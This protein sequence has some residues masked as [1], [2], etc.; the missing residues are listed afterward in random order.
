MHTQTF[1]VLPEH[2]LAYAQPGKPDSRFVAATVTTADAATARTRS[3]ERIITEQMQR[4]AQWVGV[5]AKINARNCAAQPIRLMRKARHGK[6]KGPGWKRVTDRKA[7]AYVRSLA[8][9]VSEYAN[10]A[11]DI[12]EVTDHPILDV[13]RRPSALPIWGVGYNFTVQRFLDKEMTGNAFTNVVRKGGIG[14]QMHRLAPHK[15]AVMPSKTEWIEGYR[16]GSEDLGKIVYKPEDV[17]HG[18]HMPSPYSPYLGVSW[19][20]DIIM[21]ADR[22][23]ASTA[24]DLSLKKNNNRPDWLLRLPPNTNADQIKQAREEVKRLFGGPERRGGVLMAT[25]EGIEVPA[26]SPADLEDVA[27]RADAK[28]IIQAAAGVPEA[29]FAMNDSNRASAIMALQQYGR[30]TILPR[31]TQDH[32]EMT[33]GL[34]PFF[35]LDPGDYWLCYDN[36][37]PDDQAVESER[38]VKLLNAGVLTL[39]EARAEDGYEPY[40]DGVGEKPRFN[41][42]PLDVMGTL[43]MGGV[44]PDGTTM[45]PGEEGEQE[46]PKPAAA[47]VAPGQDVQATALN[48]AQVTALN[49]LLQAVADGQLPGESASA[50]IAASY[51]TL[52]PEQI[53][54]M[55]DP[56][57]GF[58]PTKP[59]V[60]DGGNQGAFG[61]GESGGGDG[62]AGG[63]A[64]ESSK[65]DKGD[66]SGGAGKSTDLRP[67]RHNRGGHDGGGGSGSQVKHPAY[68]TDWRT[69]DDDDKLIPTQ[70]EAV[71]KLDTL[72]REWYAKVAG[73]LKAGES[74]DA[75]VM[76]RQSEL[77]ALLRPAL[78]QLMRTAAAAELAQMGAGPEAFEVTP[79]AALRY[80]DGYTPKLAAAITQETTEL[81]KEAQATGVA[82]GESIPQIQER[83]AAA[84][85][86]ETTYRAERIARTETQ[87]IFGRG[88]L[89]AWRATGIERK[90]WLLAPNSCALCQECAAKGAIPINEPFFVDE[91]G[92]SDG[93]SRPRHP[94][95]VCDGVAVQDTTPLPEGES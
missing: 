79:Q 35:G 57:K 46:Q 82:M 58:E 62:S 32:D 59:E 66:D 18:I 89:E 14:A 73:S 31:L 9:K 5:C 94:N 21:D 29:I 76:A 11:D 80:L 81:L 67:A 41:G 26:W 92:W 93:Q 49:A 36:P 19:I 72:L 23:S 22:Y 37:V 83:V 70:Q 88:D 34:L 51:P 86:E 44:G 25:A 13:L 71:A 48:G 43:K 4:C 95:C 6:P 78:E 64:G 65:G 91:S 74:I 12:E 17:Y 50:A 68:R 69:K 8:G 84:L 56:L 40:E 39:D 15:T 63:L 61:G 27:S 77:Q 42:V 75:A 87:H 90:Q 30:L 33:I 38:Q 2:A 52:T 28:Q 60:P 54:A 53:A 16:Y 7:L 20:V 85:G 1:M 45:V 24:A 47:G 10:E 3:S 55:V